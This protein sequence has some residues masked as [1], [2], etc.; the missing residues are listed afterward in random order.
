MRAA[1]RAGDAACMGVAPPAV[2]STAQ[3][4]SGDPRDNALRLELEREARQIAEQALSRRRGMF[5]TLSPSDR[6]DVATVALRV[7]LRL[8]DD[9]AA[10][11]GRN[12]RLRRALAGPA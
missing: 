8:A 3:P 7:A 12:P 2:Q 9:L 5:A 11:A 4:H 10:E 6:D 1:R